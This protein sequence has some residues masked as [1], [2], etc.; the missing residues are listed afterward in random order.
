M[1]DACCAPF[2]FLGRLQSMVLSRQDLASWLQ[3]MLSPIPLHPTP[4]RWRFA[5]AIVSHQQVAFSRHATDLQAS[6]P[7]VPLPPMSRPAWLGHWRRCDEPG[8]TAHRLPGTETANVICGRL[9]MRIARRLYSKVAD[10]CLHRRPFL[11]DGCSQLSTNSFGVV[12]R[13]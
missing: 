8:A 11:R 4:T 3:R 2:G 5:E 7:P 12:R 13:P 9:I 6:G 10:K 1:H